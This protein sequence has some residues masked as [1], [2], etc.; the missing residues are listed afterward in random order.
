MSDSDAVYVSDEDIPDVETCQQRVEQF[1][2]ITGTDEACAQFYLQDR[3][4]DLERSVNAFFEVKASA[5]ISLME[6][7]DSKAPEIIINIDQTVAQQLATIPPVALPLPPQAIRPVSHR[8]LQSSIKPPPEMTFI[9]FNIDGLNPHNLKKRTKAVCVIIFENSPDVVF[10]QEVI[11]QTFS[12]IENKLPEYKCIA[13][14]GGEYF[15][16]TLIRRF[17]TYYDSHKVIEFP[18]SCMGRNLLVTE[19]HIGPLK[20]TLLNT[21]L[22]S[23]AEHAA[24]RVR[25]LQRSFKEVMATPKDRVVIFAG[26][27][28]LRDKEVDLIGGLPTGVIDL[29][30]AGGSRKECRYTWDMTRNTNTELPGRFKPRRRFDRAYLRQSLP[31]TLRPKFFGLIGLEKISGTQS[32][33][34]DHWGIMV[35][36]DILDPSNQ[37]STASSPHKR[38]KVDP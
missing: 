22:E 29:W 23:T 9:T 1:A 4:W 27:L 38:Q 25:Q 36:F 32:F 33:P 21:H 6:D 18:S 24:E 15:T 13:S 19:A 30:V 17:T 5:G 20:L 37:S 28:N 8:N 7:H 16:A 12:Y 3:K 34:S 26:D 14:G 35:H 10:L 31:S 11:P 2:Q